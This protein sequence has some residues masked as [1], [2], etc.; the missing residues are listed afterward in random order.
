MTRAWMAGLGIGSL[1]LASAA[2]ASERD[3]FTLP[4]EELARM[5]VQIATGTPKPIAIAPASTTVITAADIE[6]MGARDIGEVLQAVPGLHVS[7]ASFNYAPRYFIRGITSTYNPHTLVLINGIPMTSLFTG[8]RGER[9]A[10]V[11]GMP[12]R[13]LERIEDHRLP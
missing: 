4:L 10:S 9:A 13:L 8:D 3:L 6:A 2:G 5:E 7:N 11:F 1:L 12:V